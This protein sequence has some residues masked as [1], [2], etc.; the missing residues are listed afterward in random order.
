[1]YGP[2]LTFLLKKNILI[3]FLTNKQKENNMRMSTALLR[4][5]N[6]KYAIDEAFIWDNTP[7]GDDFWEEIHNEYYEYYKEKELKQE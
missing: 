6:T 1:M 5:E 4:G 3:Q 2:L 7:E